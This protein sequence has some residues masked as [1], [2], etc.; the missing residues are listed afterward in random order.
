MLAYFYRNRY[1][2]MIVTTKCT[3]TKR[4]TTPFHFVR[5]KVLMI[6]IEFTESG[7]G[8][9]KNFSFN[10]DT[11]V[12]RLLPLGRIASPRSTGML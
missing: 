8:K 5:V 3:K 1:I 12:Y 10:L 9:Y 4:S 11:A 6:F 7:P 2:I